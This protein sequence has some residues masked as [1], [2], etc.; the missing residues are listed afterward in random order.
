MLDQLDQSMKS[1]QQAIHCDTSSP[2]NSFMMAY[3]PIEQHS[4]G[5]VDDTTEDSVLEQGQ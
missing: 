1:M 2:I 3:L 5:E 4:R